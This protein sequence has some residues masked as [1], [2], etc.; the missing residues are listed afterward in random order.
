MF[1]LFDSL[2][3]I[4]LIL[5]IPHLILKRKW[6]PRF[7]TRFGL[8]RS[9]EVKAFKEKENIWIHAVSVGEIISVLDIITQLQEQ[10]PRDRIVCSTVTKTG[11]RLAQEKLA[12]KCLVIYAPFDFS[13]VVHHMISIIRPKLYIATETEI[14][15]NFFLALTKRGIPAIL[16]NGRISDKS[17]KGYKRARYLT[18]TVLQCMK[19][20]CMQS[21]EDVKRIIHL[22]ADGGKVAMAGNLKFDQLPSKDIVK[23]RIGFE[24]KTQLLVAGSTHPG[25]EK[26]MIDTY[27]SL[28]TEFPMLRLII[29]PRHIERA[30]EVMSIVKSEKFLPVKLSE[31]GSRHLSKGDIVIVD[32]IGHLRNLYAQAS[33]VF[34]GKTFTVGGGQNMIEPLSF[35]VPTF[36]GPRTENFTDV[37]RILLK[38]DVIEQVLTAE[39]LLAKMKEALQHLEKMKAKAGRGQRVIEQNRGA[40]RKTLEAIKHVLSTG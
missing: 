27:R 14:W 20:F 32:A 5:Y 21:S 3:L 1:I 24:E 40:T 25:E 13:F 11:Y 4:F 26:M 31:I 28:L 34:I 30:E 39:E 29:A 7:S 9:E 38:E 23:E 16:I 12:P 2:C 19:K 10:Y 22:G 15:P 18:K 33:L 36:V 17:F 6:H 35:G 8:Y 37:M